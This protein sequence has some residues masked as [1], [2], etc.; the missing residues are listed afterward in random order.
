[1]LGWYEWAHYLMHAPY[2]PKSQWFRNVSR[3]HVLHH[4]KNEHY[5]FGVTTSIGDRVLG[6]R[7]DGS[8]IPVSPTVRT[9][10]VDLA[11][12]VASAS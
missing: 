4:F 3:N 11:A 8:T 12:D 6:T 9:L 7:P 10:G 2:R 5:W 1:M